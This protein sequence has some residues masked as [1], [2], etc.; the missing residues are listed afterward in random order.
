MKDPVYT[1][2]TMLHPKYRK[3]FRKYCTAEDYEMAKLAML[4]ETVKLCAAQEDED[5]QSIS[6]IGD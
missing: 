3:I 5:S 6:S 4:K 2:P 1:T